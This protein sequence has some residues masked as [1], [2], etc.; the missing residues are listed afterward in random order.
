MGIV[1][2]LTGEELALWACV[3]FLG[4]CFPFLVHYHHFCFQN[5]SSMMIVAGQTPF[6]KCHIPEGDWVSY[7]SDLLLTFV[8]DEHSFPEL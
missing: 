7:S 2:G 5:V 8:P 4:W 1:L 6:R 3:C